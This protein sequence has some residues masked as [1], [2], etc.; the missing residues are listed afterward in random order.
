MNNEFNPLVSIVIPVYNGANYM[1][2]AIDSALAQTYKNI[3][4]LVINDGSKDGGATRDIA[5]S[6]GNRIRYFEKDNGGV[7][8]ALNLG[9]REMKG[10]Y[11]SWLSHDDVYSIEKI[12]KQ[13]ECL[14]LK[15]SVIVYSDYEYL[16]QTK[17]IINKNKLYKEVKKNGYYALLFNYIHGCT[18]LIP[19]T[20]FIKS[21]LFDENLDTVNDY[22]L[23]FRLVKDYEFYY[24]N[25]KSVK[26]RIHDKQDSKIKKEKHYG[27]CNKL[28]IKF[29]E[30][31]TLNEIFN[32]E[33]DQ[34]VFY[35][36]LYN[37]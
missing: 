9:I 26:V 1:R 7:A 27:D 10:E 19:K 23:F 31:M 6:Y 30:S 37:Y 14:N 29:I 32:L 8:T 12:K 35:R 11:F 34:Y 4:V 24:V 28:W 33:H 18:L 2:E 3:E 5:L 20:C 36:K 21:G 16:A 22:E 15:D 17:K 25:I 13:I